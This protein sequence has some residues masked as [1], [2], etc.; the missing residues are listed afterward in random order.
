[1]KLSY[2]KIFISFIILLVLLIGCSA[3]AFTDDFGNFL[4]QAGETGAGYSSDQGASQGADPLS[5]AFLDTVVGKI[6]ATVVSLIG[7]IFLIFTIYSGI[8]WML[9]SGNEEMISKAKK[10]LI[11][12]SVGVGLTLL[13]FVVAN[14]AFGFLNQEF[15][16]TPAPGPQPPAGLEQQACE[17]SAQCADRQFQ[18]YCLNNICVECRDSADCMTIG[19]ANLGYLWCD[20][21]WH[22]CS[23]SPASGGDCPVYTNPDDCAYNGCWWEN[24]QCINSPYGPLLGTNS[25]CSQSQSYEECDSYYSYFC[26]WSA[27]ECQLYVNTINSCHLLQDDCYPINGQNCEWNTITNNCQYAN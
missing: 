8:Q 9:A 12:G 2:K 20:P 24:G 5:M 4:K 7:I 11:N 27:S 16:K 3:L 13:A 1:M 10:R 18:I 23:N 14:M 25:S 26:V 19:R 17:T 6:V 21:Q 22:V 15:L